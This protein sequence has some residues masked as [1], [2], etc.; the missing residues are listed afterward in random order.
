MQVQ[1]EE[2]LSHW[3]K[4]YDLDGDVVVI[5]GLFTDDSAENIMTES[6]RAIDVLRTAEMEYIYMGITGG[7]MHMARLPLPL[8]LP[9][10]E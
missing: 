3:K 9:S 7:T 5:E 2:K 8:L 1:L 6:L 4:Q 10:Q